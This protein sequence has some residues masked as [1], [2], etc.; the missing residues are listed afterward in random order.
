M[1]PPLIR[2]KSQP[3]ESLEE[4]L[5]SAL[6][7]ARAPRVSFVVPAGSLAASLFVLRGVDLY[8]LR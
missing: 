2:V 5:Q 6:A 3:G 8:Q 4:L 1:T 7:L